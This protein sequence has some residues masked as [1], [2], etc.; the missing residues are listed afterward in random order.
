VTDQFLALTLLEQTFVWFPEDILCADAEL[1]KNNMAAM[2]K[3]S[4]TVFR[5]F[6]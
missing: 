5:R 4:A 1:A 2:T 6:L 3:T